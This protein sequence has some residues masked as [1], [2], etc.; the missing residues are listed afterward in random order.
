MRESIHS[1]IYANNFYS[2]L[3]G[4]GQRSKRSSRS[5]DRLSALAFGSSVVGARTAAQHSAAAC[6]LALTLIT[7]YFF[8]YVLDSGL[9]VISFFSP[10]FFGCCVRW[11]AARDLCFSALEVCAS[12]CVC[13]CVCRQTA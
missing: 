4:S 10:S 12:A 11:D 2:I 6:A 8:T 3:L 13:V 1:H 9:V 5:I 7:C